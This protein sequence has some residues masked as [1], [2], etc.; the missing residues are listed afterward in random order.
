V[1]GHEAGGPGAAC[2]LQVQPVRVYLPRRGGQHPALKFAAAAG[3][4]RRQRPL[5]RLLPGTYDGTRVI[6]QGLCLF[7]L[8]G[9]SGHQKLL[10]TAK[11]SAFQ[12]IFI[13]FV[14]V[15]TIKNQ[16]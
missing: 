3:T 10:R 4:R 1:G 2:R 15:K 8:F 13:E 11:R 12:S 6:L 9:A 16:T 7:Q 14:W 5:R